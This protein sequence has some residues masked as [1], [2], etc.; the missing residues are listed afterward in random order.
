MSPPS[1]TLRPQ[2]VGGGS[3]SSQ[4]AAHSLLGLSHIKRSP[5]WSFNGR[6]SSNRD[7]DGPGPGAY[8]TSSPDVTSR[9]K[10]SANHAFGTSGRETT[11]KNRVPGPGAYSDRRGIGSAGK[12]FSLTPRRQGGRSTDLTDHPGPGSHELRSTIGE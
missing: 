8:L 5:K 12:A 10:K 9:F 3:V 7:K 4:V 1:E 6:H 11:D 2:S